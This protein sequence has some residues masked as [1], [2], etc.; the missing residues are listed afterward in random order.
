MRALAFWDGSV[1]SGS[2]L[3]RAGSVAS[4]YLARWTP[5]SASAVEGGVVPVNRAMLRVHPNPFNPRT[6]IRYTVPAAGPVEVAV[7]DLAGRRVTTLWSGHREAGPHELVWEGRD[8]ASGPAAAG[9]YLVRVAQGRERALQ[10][11]TLVK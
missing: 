1:W 2:N 4:S 9:V 5:E 3:L 10:K 6:T 8:A 7:F 11:V